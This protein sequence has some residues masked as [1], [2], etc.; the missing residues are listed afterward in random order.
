MLKNRRARRSCKAETMA[1]YLRH[2]GDLIV[3]GAIMPV[4]TPV[5]ARR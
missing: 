2:V 5:L 1:G 4:V 3:I